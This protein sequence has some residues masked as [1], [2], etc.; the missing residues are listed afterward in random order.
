MIVAVADTHSFIWYLD[1]DRRLSEIAKQ[2]IDRATQTGDDIGIS[3]ITLVETVYLVEKGRVPRQTL[4]RMIA[5]VQSPQ[6]VFVELPLDVEVV[7][8]LQQVSRAEVPD[9][10]DRIIAATAL[11]FQVPVIS[12]DA[13]IQAANLQTIW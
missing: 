13:K 3:A 2:A 7:Q 9:M 5:E 4:A 12:R 1:A 10:P 6:S 11:H 8:A